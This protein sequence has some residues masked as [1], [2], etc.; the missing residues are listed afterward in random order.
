MVVF[1]RPKEE[2]GSY[3]QWKEDNI[4]PQVVFE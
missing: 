4:A 3:Q 2:R 1:C